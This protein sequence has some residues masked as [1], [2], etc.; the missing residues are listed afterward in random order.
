[1]GRDP[2]MGCSWNLYLGDLRPRHLS[3]R[4]APGTGGGGTQ[5][6]H[7]DG[8][9]GSR[10]DHGAA[11]EP[12]MAK[13]DPLEAEYHANR[14]GWGAS[15]TR[16][17]EGAERNARPRYHRATGR[18]LLAYEPRQRYAHG[19]IVFRS[20]PRGNQGTASAGGSLKDP[21]PLCH[22]RDFEWGFLPSNRVRT[23]QLNCHEG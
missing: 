13:R 3:L 11:P 16:S 15:Q 14:N 23:V 18:K 9:S 17:L 6:S 12:G 21:S 5:T 20:R 1:M 10:L 7:C 22:P 19:L 8:R 2:G 4:D